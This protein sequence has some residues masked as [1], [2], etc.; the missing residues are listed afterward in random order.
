MIMRLLYN[1]KRL[2]DTEQAW[3]SFLVGSLLACSFIYLVLTESVTVF[4]SAL[5]LIAIGVILLID[6]N[7]GIGKMVFLFQN[8][9]FLGVGVVVSL[10]FHVTGLLLLYLGITVVLV[11]VTWTHRYRIKRKST[12]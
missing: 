5:G 3:K 7:M 4:F 12:F 2:G 10:F 6:T 11:I 9:L 8:L 1:P